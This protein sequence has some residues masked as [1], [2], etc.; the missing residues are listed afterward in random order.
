MRP[1]QTF[2]HGINWFR[3]KVL[4]WPGGALLSLKCRYPI[5]FCCPYYLARTV[6][7]APLFVAD[8]LC[9]LLCET[10]TCLTLLHMVLCAPPAR[11][12]MTQELMGDQAEAVTFREVTLMVGRIWLTDMHAYV[13]EAWDSLGKRLLW[14]SRA[15]LWHSGCFGWLGDPY[16]DDAL[17]ARAGLLVEED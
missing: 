12:A 16:D 8:L 1:D 5:R 7:L 3:A 11:A 4:A 2:C 6:L 13:V 14:S 10:A 17:L 9:E 15:A